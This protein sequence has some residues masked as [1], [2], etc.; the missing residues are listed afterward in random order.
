MTPSSEKELSELLQFA[1]GPVDVIGGNTR[2]DSPRRGMQLSTSHLS[3]I[4]DYIPGAL[5]M[6]ARAGTPLSEIEETLLAEGQQLAFEPLILDQV[7]GRA[8]QSTIGGV[9]ATNS[10]GSRRI[11]AGAARDFLLGVRFIDGSGRLIKNGGRVMKNVTGYD[12]VKL[13]AG[14][15]GT[16]GVL[17]EVSF[18]VLPRPESNATLILALSDHNEAVSAMAAALGSPYDVSGT[19]YLPSE[20]QCL[21]R[22][23]GFPKS[24]AH[25][26]AC[27][28]EKLKAFGEIEVLKDAIAKELW[29]DIRRL[30]SLKY[31]DDELWRISVKPSDGPEVFA[32]VGFKS[33]FYDWAGGL[34][35]GVLTAGNDPRHVL[36]DF[37]GH[38]TR[39]R[40]R[41]QTVA[42][43]HPKSEIVRDLNSAIRKR[44][45]PKG[46]LN[47]GLMG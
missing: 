11:Q 2:S 44:F 5:T 26:V 25:R 24:V 32:K 27:L 28:K 8:G 6:V 33:G 19:A 1:N 14:S 29:E 43:F 41:D 20:E 34:I 36:E 9:F 46:I 22:V 18:K 12:L 21:I 47:V 17:T 40:G 23:E 13:M 15:W 10:S 42:K 35:W 39:I 38:A 31:A 3:G 7:M 30:G 45:D 4:V 16:L 37:E